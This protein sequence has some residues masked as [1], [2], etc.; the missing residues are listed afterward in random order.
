MDHTWEWLARK[1]EQAMKEKWNQSN[2]RVMEG[3]KSLVLTLDITFNKGKMLKE[4]PGSYEEELQ[5][6]KAETTRQKTFIEE[7]WWQK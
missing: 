5:K 3:L 2:E 6:R 4:L 7:V 1:T